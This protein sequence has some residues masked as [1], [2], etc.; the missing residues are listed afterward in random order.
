MALYLLALW[1]FPSIPKPDTNNPRVAR[2]CLSAKNARASCLCNLHPRVHHISILLLHLLSSFT[3]CLRALK[4]VAGFNI[5]ATFLTQLVNLF[6]YHVCIA[7][8][9]IYPAEI[10][11]L[12]FFSSNTR[13]KCFLMVTKLESVNSMLIKCYEMYF[14]TTFY[15]QMFAI[16][17]LFEF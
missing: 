3:C 16:W 6:Q 2:L 4:I 5:Y 8:C 17:K 10:V 12:R 13:F 7:R 9:W 1:H 15:F 14:N 11:T